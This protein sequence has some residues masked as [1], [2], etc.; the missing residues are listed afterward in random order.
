[1]TKESNICRLY[2]LKK[3]VLKKQKEELLAS[4]PK[5]KQ[6]ALKTAKKY[7]LL[8]A[9]YG[10]NAAKNPFPETWEDYEKTKKDVE[11]HS[12]Q[13]VSRTYREK[14]SAAYR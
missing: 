11:Q 5:D 9:N 14:V 8:Q 10:R 4:L 7:W 3:E 13:S 6:V 12:A 2:K 1:M